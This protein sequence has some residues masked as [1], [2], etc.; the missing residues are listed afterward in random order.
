MLNEKEIQLLLLGLSFTPVQKADIPELE[1]DLYEF[2]RKLRLIFHFHNDIS[3]DISL[4]KRK[5]LYCP[6]RGE[7]E[8]LERICDLLETSGIITR[9]SKYNLGELRSALVTL[10]SKVKNNKISY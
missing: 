2:T 8:E 7:N 6:N 9:K 3:E 5:S 4:I 10:E 1:A